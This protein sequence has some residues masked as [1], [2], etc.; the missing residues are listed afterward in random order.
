MA[1]QEDDKGAQALQPRLDRLVMGWAATAVLVG[2][3]AAAASW[4]AGGPA[5]ALWL[6]ATLWVGTVVGGVAVVNVHYG[7]WRESISPIEI[8]AVLVMVLLPPHWAVLI[9]ITAVPVFEGVVTQAAPRKMTFNT[10]WQVT[11]TAVG[12]VVFHAMAGPQFTAAPWDVVAATVAAIVF[13]TTNAVAFVGLTAALSG[14]RWRA[15][16]H[17][18]VSTRVP[19]NLGMGMTGVLAAVLATRAPAA[20][21]LLAVPTAMDYVRARAQRQEMEME[22]AKTQAEAANTA[23]NEFLSTMSHEVRTPLTAIMGF[24]HLLQRS[25][26][27]ERDEEAVRHILK[28][29][30]HLQALMDDMLDL[31]SIEAGAMVLATD[32]VH[33]GQLIE[34]AVALIQPMAD[35]RSIRMVTDTAGC[36]VHLTTDQ[37]RCKQILLNLLSNAVKYNRHGGEVTVLWALRDGGWVRISVRDDGPGIDPSH[38]QQLFQP[39]DRLGAEVTGVQGTGLGLALTKK[40]VEVMGG[41]IG[42]DSAPGRGATFWFDLPVDG[43]AVPTPAA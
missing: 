23:K 9:A 10:A 3:G 36:D 26:L 17:E 12:S 7:G 34:D 1:V 6:V 5:P 38:L 16:V 39:F 32:T 8:A 27:G 28:A 24:G 14:R 4:S 33:V 31:S 13:V 42:V 29:G 22:M 25:D 18:E 15:Q 41:A 43:P 20:L 40:L 35:D 21:P 2:G 19:L 11:G 30:R 37:R